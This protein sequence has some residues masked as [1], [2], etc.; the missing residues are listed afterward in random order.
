MEF[1]ENMPVSEYLEHYGTQ[2]MKWGIRRYQNEDGTLTAL[3]RIHYGLGPHVGKG[4][5][6]PNPF[7]KK[8]KKEDGDSSESKSPEKELSKEDIMKSGDAK[9]ILKNMDKLTDSELQAAY[10]RANTVRNLQNLT[11]SEAK[12]KDPNLFQKGVK[13][14]TDA[15]VAELASELTATAKVGVKSVGEKVINTVFA[16]DNAKRNSMLKSI[17]AKTDKEKAEEE[18][19]RMVKSLIQAGNKTEILKNVDKMTNQEVADA[20]KRMQNINNIATGSKDP[21]IEQL[22]EALKEKE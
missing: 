21:T 18:R 2:G 20:A 9:L 14:I 17:G 19:A 15:M 16:D 5:P 1:D 6:L 4:K 3:G 13:T 11:P 10:N 7:K 8:E 22:L 12:K